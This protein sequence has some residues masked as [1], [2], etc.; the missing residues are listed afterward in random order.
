[1]ES[2]FSK[3]FSSSFSKPFSSP[4]RAGGCCQE[5][6]LQNAAAASVTVILS[7][8]EKVHSTPGLSSRG[9]FSFQTVWNQA[10]AQGGW[11]E[12]CRTRR[13]G[14]EPGWF[15]TCQPGFVMCREG[16]WKEDPQNLLLL[17]FV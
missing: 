3:P 2:S 8:P 11:A 17:G 16:R 5:S 13:A 14:A 4:E 15:L 9:A 10:L 12:L 7:H 6:L 1:M